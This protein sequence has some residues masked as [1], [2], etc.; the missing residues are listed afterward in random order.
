MSQAE[1]RHPEQ[2]DQS[3]EG[4]DLPASSP[5][6]LDAFGFAVQADDPMGGSTVSGEAVNDEQV[7]FDADGV[8]AAQTVGFEPDQANDREAGYSGNSQVESQEEDQPDLLHE[9]AHWPSAD[10]THADEALT[11]E[12]VKIDAVEGP[13]IDAGG[14]DVA[15]GVDAGISSLPAKSLTTRT[16]GP[17]AINNPT[18]PSIATP[19]RRPARP[20]APA[21][22]SDSVEGTHPHAPDHATI[23]E[24]VLPARHAA[25]IRRRWLQRVMPFAASMLLH[26]GLVVLG[27]AVVQGT[28]APVNLQ[29]EQIIIPEA[30]LAE[31]GLTGAIPNPGLQEADPGVTAN[32]LQPP[33]LD[34]HMDSRGMSLSGQPITDDHM[35]GNEALI[36]LGPGQAPGSIRD[37]GNGSPGLGQSNIAAFG[38]PGGSLAGSGLRVQFMGL[39][40]NARRVVLLCDASATMLGGRWTLAREEMKKTIDQLKPVQAFNIVLFNGSGAPAFRNE[41]VMATD[42]NRAAAKEFIDKVALASSDDPTDAIRAAFRMNPELMFVLT[43]GF[44]AIKDNDVGQVAVLFDAL[45]PGHKVKVNILLVRSSTDD[46]LR[47]LMQA[48][49][50]STGGAFKLLDDQMR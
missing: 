16:Q 17:D 45:N 38:M 39:G 33:Q 9:P 43:D 22:S 42:E 25:M 34:L 49:A 5:E 29:R 30:Q 1:G 10:D 50:A 37:Q 4:L 15:D 44:E 24:D 14:D 47:K 21:P 23:D 13:D 11:D 8:P 35:T 20:V 6:A 32:T 46:S 41:L 7:G 3:P 26:L 36:G 27:L 18:L 12:P 48:V 19:L 40:G 2:P 28:A 31:K